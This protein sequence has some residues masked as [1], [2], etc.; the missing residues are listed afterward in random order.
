MAFL[1]GVWEWLK[2][3]GKR[4]GTVFIRY[5]LA[6]AATVFLVVAAVAVAASGKSLQIG[7]LLQRLWGSKKPENLR[8]TVAEDRKTDEGR[9]IEPGASDDKGFVQSPVSTEIVEPGMFS[10]PDTVT[11]VHPEKGKVVID[12]PEGVK[13]K[14][15]HEVVEVSPDVYEV[16]NRD[17]GVPVKKIDDV[18]KKF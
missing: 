5:P 4:V 10:N 14:D 13:N 15:V 3:L 11:V 6:A 2:A 12:L 17:K 8:A 16:K 9:P 18:L 7:G 1:K